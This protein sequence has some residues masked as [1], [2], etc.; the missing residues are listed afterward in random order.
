MNGVLASEACNCV[1][2][3]ITGYSNGKRGARQWQYDGRSGEL[4]PSDLPSKV[5]KPTEPTPA[6]LVA[7]T[8]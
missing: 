6:P 5:Q 2:D 3:L 1:L 7:A 8:I 4:V